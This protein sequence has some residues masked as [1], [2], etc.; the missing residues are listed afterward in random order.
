LDPARPGSDAHTTVSSVI[1]LSQVSWHCYFEADAD[2]PLPSLII[3]CMNMNI[4]VH[5]WCSWKKEKELPQRHGSGLSWTGGIW[6]RMFYL[7]QTRSLRYR[8][9]FE[10]A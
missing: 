6:A 1:I 5:F 2:H 3:I 8:A 4:W 9:S 10:P 7:K